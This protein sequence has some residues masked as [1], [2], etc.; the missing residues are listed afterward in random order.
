MINWNILADAGEVDA[1]ADRSHE[2]PCVIFK[3]STRCSISALARH[4]LDSQWDLEAEL[5]TPYFLDIF[6]H[7]PVS[8]YVAERFDVFHESPQ[9]LL[10]H[11]GECVYETSHLDITVS[12]LKEQ[13]TTLAG[14]Q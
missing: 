7:R 8:N 3:H 1:I 9:L 4:R 12:E 10:I 13:L 5:V 11:Q 2:K 6:A 14:E